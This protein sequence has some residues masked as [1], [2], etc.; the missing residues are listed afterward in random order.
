MCGCAELIEVST[1]SI[2]YQCVKAMLTTVRTRTATAIQNVPRQLLLP[3]PTDGKVTLDVG[4]KVGRLR[5][6][7]LTPKRLELGAPLEFLFGR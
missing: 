1:L 3:K 5:A 7:G 2:T 6:H 4:P